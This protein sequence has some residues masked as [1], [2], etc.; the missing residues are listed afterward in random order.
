MQNIIFVCL[1]KASVTSAVLFF[2]VVSVTVFEAMKQF[3]CNALLRFAFHQKSAF[4]SVNVI[5]CMQVN[6]PFNSATVIF[7]GWCYKAVLSCNASSR[8]TYPQKNVLCSANAII[9]KR[10][11]ESFATQRLF[12][13][14]DAMK[15]FYEK[16]MKN[17]LFRAKTSKPQTTHRVDFWRLIPEKIKNLFLCRHLGVL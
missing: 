6:E 5:T 17:P 10:I 4:C 7:W 3:W 11:N 1:T 12:F 9:R 15:Q 2:A 14:G 16:T 13:E 8:L